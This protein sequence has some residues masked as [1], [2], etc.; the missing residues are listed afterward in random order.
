[1]A[2]PRSS[3]ACPNCN[4]LYEMIRQEA[5]SETVNSEITCCACGGPLPNR[6][7]QVRS[8]IFP[9]AEGW[10]NPAVAQGPTIAAEDIFQNRQIVKKRSAFKPISRNAR[11]AE[12]GSSLIRPTQVKSPSQ[13]VLWPG[14]SWSCLRTLE[15]TSVFRLN[16]HRESNEKPGQVG[17]PDRG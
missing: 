9:I 2:A 4:A 16:A 11:Q 15:G 6:E 13:T 12:R 10:A 5:G 3:F 1:M 7:G 8:Q 17:A 14:L